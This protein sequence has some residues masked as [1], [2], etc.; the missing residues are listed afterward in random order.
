MSRVVWITGASSG[1]GAALARALAARGDAVAASAR[2]VEKLE[3]LA[4]E[5]HGVRAYPC[6]VRDAAAVSATAASIRERLGEIDVAVLNAGVGL[7]ER[8]GGFRAAEFES[9]LR[10]NLMGVAHGLEAVLPAMSA[11]RQ[12]RIVV[13]ASLAGYRG[14]PNAAYYCASKAA[15]IALCESLR[16]D[17]ERSG[18]VL[19][20]VNPG[21]VRTP[22]T[23]RNRFKM[24]MLMEVDDAAARIVRGMAGERFE[25]TFPRRF[26]LALNLARC[27][28]YPLFFALVKRVTGH[29][30]R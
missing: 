30:T 3:R 25:I 8:A 1:I 15:L 12:G 20:V 18:V 11:R 14:L 27:L 7:A 22:M 6:D 28:P 9:L 19:Q 16:F 4:A 2:S 17:A 10:V 24:P 26:A 13:V 21:F 23:D 29:G 5:H